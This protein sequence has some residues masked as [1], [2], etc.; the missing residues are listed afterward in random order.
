M[1]HS[2]TRTS[3]K[4][5]GQPFIGTCTKCGQVGLT[6]GD[7]HAHCPNPADLSDADALIVA[8]GA[9]PKEPE[10]GQS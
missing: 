8:I 1:S 9:Q 4:G 5:P 7:M 6:L 3:P 2:L 10:H